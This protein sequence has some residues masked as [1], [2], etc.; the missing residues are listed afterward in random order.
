M[1]KFKLEQVNYSEDQKYV[2]RTGLI[3]ESGNYPDKKF[4]MTP[5]ELKKAASEFK[6]AEL[7]VEHLRQSPLDGRIGR[8]EYVQASEDG[9]KLYGSVRMPAW[10]HDNVYKDQP[11]KVSCTWSRDKKELKKLALTLTPRVSDAVLMAA[12]S[13]ERLERNEDEKLVVRDFFAWFA[14]DKYEAK[15]D[16]KKTNKGQGHM[17]QLHD[18]ACGFGAVCDKSNKNEKSYSYF[19]SEEENSTIQK[20]HDMA[21]KSG[22][23]CDFKRDWSAMYSDTEVKNMSLRS[24]LA[25]LLKEAGEEEVV[26][27]SEAAELPE[28]TALKAKVA[29]LETEVA[30]FKAAAK[31]EEKAVEEPAKDPKVVELEAKVAELEGEK[32]RVQGAAFAAE[33]VKKGI[34]APA[35]QGDIASFYG[36]LVSDDAGVKVEVGFSKDGKEVKGSRVEA[37]TALFAGLKPSELTEEAFSGVGVLGDSDFSEEDV[38][39][40]AKN[41]AENYLKRVNRSKSA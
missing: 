40:E 17:Q 24:K 39:K 18:I 37:F 16:Y 4:K 2:W 9:T 33:L 5:A 31:V 19:A 34:V 22:A 14:A 20:V 30:G 35:S 23:G 13:Q 6:P 41:Q 26:T 21:V 11:L 29:S 8:L 15:Y 3:F 12:F 36:Q 38:A 32:V 28:V 7:D 27:N 10:F 1:S 25:E